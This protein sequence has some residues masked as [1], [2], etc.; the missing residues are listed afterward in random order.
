MSKGSSPPDRQLSS[1]ESFL[2]EYQLV[3]LTVTVSGVALVGVLVAGGWWRGNS[4][5]VSIAALALIAGHASW[6]RLRHIRAPRS[7]IVMDSTLAG[8]LMFT[9][10]DYPSA[11]TGIFGLVALVV[12]YFANG[13]WISVFLA[14]LTAWY[15]TALLIGSGTSVEAIGNLTGSLLAVAAALAIALR[16]R[17]WLGRLDANRSQLVG[18]VGH[19]LRNNL[20]GMLGLTDVVM[21]MPDLE[22][23][24]AHELIALAHQQAVDATEIVEDL[25]T[26]SRLEG[27]A[28]SL[29]TERVDVNA[30]IVDTARRF[31]GTG[32]EIGFELASDLPSAWA[33]SLRVRQILR[34]LISNAI[35]YGGPEV[36]ITSRVMGDTVQL[37]V[38]DDGDGVPPEDESS[39]FLPYRRSMKGRR[40][41][42]SVGLGLWI[43]R[44]LAQG[45]RGRLDYLRRDGLTEFAL[46]LPTNYP[47]QEARTATS[48]ALTFG[49][50]ADSETAG[51]SNVIE[52]TPT[53]DEATAVS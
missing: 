31:Q 48:H 49:Q 19:E 10:P 21:S 3:R 9:I 16:V 47:D 14:Y 33:D 35:R 17:G 5:T 15:V 7:M 22:P 20:T 43:C 41:E 42:S 34:N 4:P 50:A 11:M 38:T 12:V 26:A 24:E 28:L 37:A 13:R 39:I 52:G 32:T 40:D 25:L 30:E 18:T 51:R 29:S 27:A 8:V 45:M 1:M 2:D 44:Q 46:T 6:V 53:A 36:A 23:N